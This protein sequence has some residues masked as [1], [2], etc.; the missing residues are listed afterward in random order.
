MLMV[1]FRR[2]NL[3]TVRIGC[4]TEQSFLTPHYAAS[5]T[6]FT[7][8]NRFH[9]RLTSAAFEEKYTQ[10]ST[11]HRLKRLNIQNARETTLV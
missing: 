5:V 1:S 9:G 2:K 10:L 11:T 8:G 3:A 4:K 6:R 7:F